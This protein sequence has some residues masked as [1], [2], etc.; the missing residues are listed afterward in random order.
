MRTDERQARRAISWISFRASF[1]RVSKWAKGME[2]PWVLLQCAGYRF[3]DILDKNKFQVLPDI[4]RDIV[5]VPPVP[6]G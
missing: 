5:H 2:G 3:S 1:R 6:F 4:L